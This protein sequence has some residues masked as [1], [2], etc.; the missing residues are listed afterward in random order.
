MKEIVEE[1]LKTVKY[2]TETDRQS[3]W[4]T[5]YLN[6]VNKDLIAENNKKSCTL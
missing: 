5:E 3:K 2:L 1:L 4:Y 6:Q